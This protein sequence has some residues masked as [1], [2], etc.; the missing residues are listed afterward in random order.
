[1]TLPADLAACARLVEAQDPARFAATMAA[2]PAARARLWPLYALNLE[3]ARAP[4]A[5]PE[6]LVAEMRL[7][8][9]VDQIE[10]LAMGAP[11]SGEIASALGPLVTEIPAL[12]PLLSD[13]ANARRWEAWRDPFAHPAAL[14]TYIDQTAGNLMWA[15]ALALGAPPAAQPAVRDFARGAG[16]SNWLAAVPDL[17]AHG[18][19]PLPDPSPAAISALAGTG[20]ARIAAARRAATTVPAAA[21]PALWPGW[22]ARAR[23]RAALSEP[24]RV[25][26]GKL[27]DPQ[28]SRAAALLLRSLTG[29]W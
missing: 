26:D 14:M 1:M 25:L 19:S 5:S 10:G 17:L 18:R 9:W 15:A 29:Y 16:L 28:A 6:P 2:P 12:P 23:L 11:P 4:Y 27:P 20:L 8:W 7:Q 22:T 24:A 3:L 21:R 13:M